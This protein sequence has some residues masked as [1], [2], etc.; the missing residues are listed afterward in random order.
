MCKPHWVPNTIYFCHL[1]KELII[2]DKLGTKNVTCT[3]I[4]LEQIRY[5]L[6]CSIVSLYVYRR[7]RLPKASLLPS[8]FLISFLFKRNS[9]PLKRPIPGASTARSLGLSLLFFLLLAALSRMT[10]FS[11]AS[12]RLLDSLA[13]AAAAMPLRMDMGILS[14]FRIELLDPKACT[15]KSVAFCLVRPAA[16]VFGSAVA[17]RAVAEKTEA[18][19][20]AERRWDSEMSRRSSRSCLRREG[21]SSGMDVLEDLDL[22]G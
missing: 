21:A 18:L 5:I 1:Q 20:L 12:R 15:R 13:L 22:V 4:I 10:P 17:P 6:Y 3:F 14:C 11:L 7:D 2:F 9:A 16:K 19:R 8:N